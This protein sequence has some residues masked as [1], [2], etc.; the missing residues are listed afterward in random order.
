MRRLSTYFALSLIWAGLLAPFVPAALLSPVPACCRRNGMHHCQISSRSSRENSRATGF[1][2]PRPKCPH[3][4][5]ALF[6]AAT[7]LESEKFNLST[8]AVAG[9]IAPASF[10]QVYKTAARN[11]SAR[12]PPQSLL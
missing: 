8:P 6:A 12:A 4:T 11:Q 10:D 2:S 3:A 1:Q 9:F 5:P 7:G